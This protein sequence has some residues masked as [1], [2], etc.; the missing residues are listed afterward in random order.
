[1]HT[2]HAKCC[3]LWENTSLDIESFEN[4]KDASSSPKPSISKVTA[5]WM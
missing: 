3:V 5:S 2:E 4:W 1:M